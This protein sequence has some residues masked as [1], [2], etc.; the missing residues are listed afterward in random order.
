MKN[1]VQQQKGKET[2]NFG[3]DQSLQELGV[4]ISPNSKN[5]KVTKC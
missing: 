4:Y 5:K 1:Y 2:K 3:F